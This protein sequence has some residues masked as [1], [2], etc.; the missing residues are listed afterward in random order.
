MLLAGVYAS[1][2]I[3][4]PTKVLI[5]LSNRPDDCVSEG[6]LRQGLGPDEVVEL[7]K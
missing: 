1:K 6:G 7:F 5:G 3:S 2:K 4:G